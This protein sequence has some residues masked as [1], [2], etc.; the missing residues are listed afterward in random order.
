MTA[1]KAQAINVE[2]LSGPRTVR[3]LVERT[4]ATKQH[5]LAVLQ[6]RMAAGEVERLVLLTDSRSEICYRAM[7]AAIHRRGRSIWHW[8]ER[9]GTHRQHP[10]FDKALSI[11]LGGLNVKAVRLIGVCYRCRQRAGEI[12]ATF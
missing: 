1:T 12:P 3:W 5:V 4:G 7:P 11:A 9:C 10:T 2:L 6:R 8:C